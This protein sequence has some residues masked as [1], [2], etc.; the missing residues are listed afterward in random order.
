[1]AGAVNGELPQYWTSGG[2]AEVDFLIERDAL[3]YPVEVKSDRH[4]RSRSLALY[5]EKYRD[6]TPLKLRF[7]LKNLHLEESLLNIPLFM[8]DRLDRIL[9]LIPTI[10][11]TP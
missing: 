6:S 7:S 9:S 1:M 8:I 5:G 11:S 2:Q 10:R 3:V 4:V